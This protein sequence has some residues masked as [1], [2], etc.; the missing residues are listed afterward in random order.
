MDSLCIME[1]SLHLRIFI[2]RFHNLKPRWILVPD[3]PHIHLHVP[4]T[5]CQFSAGT[6]GVWLVTNTSVFRNGFCS[7]SLTSFACRR[8]IGD[9]LVL[10]KQSSTMQFTVEILPIMLAY[11]FWS[12]NVSLRQ[13]PSRG[14]SGYIAGRLLHA[15]LRGSTQNLDII[16]RY[17]YVHRSSMG[18][19]LQQPSSCRSTSQGLETTDYPWS[20]WPCPAQYLDRI[21]VKILTHQPLVQLQGCRHY[22]LISTMILRWIPHKSRS[23]FHWNL[24]SKCEAYHH[25][26]ENTTQWIS[27][28]EVIASTID[29]MQRSDFVD[30]YS[31]FHQTIHNCI[32]LHPVSAA[33]TQLQVPKSIFRQFLQHADALTQL[34]SCSLLHCFQAWFHCSK[35]SSLR[36]AMNL[37]SKE[38][39][40][41]RHRDLLIQARDAAAA[42]TRTFFQIIRRIS[43]KAP[44]SRFQSDLNRANYWE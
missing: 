30:D 37:Q 17:Q 32:E 22:P 14:R 33:N 5:D 1:E 23:S 24:Q 42:H 8:P 36:K 15:R 18:W 7:T 9:S 29:P 21:L 25:Y 35:R 41:L 6:A 39:R 43:P 34:S 38:V 40:K 19:T 27:Q 26:K 3:F 11:S 31:Q 4:P 28:L 13:T 20:F 2:R 16:A 12:P 44:K 10:G